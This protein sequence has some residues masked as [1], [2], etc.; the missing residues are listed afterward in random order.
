MP[1]RPTL[2]SRRRRRLSAV[3]DQLGIS[4][5]TRSYFFDSTTAAGRDSNRTG[6]ASSV[7]AEQAPCPAVATSPTGTHSY[8]AASR[9]TDP[10]FS[11]DQLGRTTALPAVGSV[12]GQGVTVGFYTNDL[13]REL[14]STLAGAAVAST[15]ILDTVPGRY[16]SIVNTGGPNAGTED[17]H[18]DDDGDNPSWNT[19][20]GAAAGSY[21]RSVTGPT[22]GLVATITNNTTSSSVAVALSNLHGDI[23]ATTTTSPATDGLLNTSDSTEYGATRDNTTSQRY[24]W[25]GAKQRAADTPGGLTLMGVRLYNPTLGRFLSVD[26]VVGGNANAYDYCT[27]DPINCTDLD[28]RF[29]WKKWIKR[30]TTVLSVAGMMG[31][32]V[33]AGVAAGLSVATGLWDVYHDRDNNGWWDVAGGGLYGAGK[34]FRYGNQAYKK[35]KMGHLPKGGESARA[36]KRARQNEAARHREF[37]RNVTNRVD[38]ADTLYGYYNLGSYGYHCRRNEC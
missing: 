16:R 3:Q 14:T 29:G 27:G 31:C 28:G 4:C 36:N 15:Y 6:Q 9:L 30:A 34:A 26:P 7:G 25:L 22:G 35:R 19:I 12:T 38:R 23:I 24:G 18:Y 8:D 11:Y 2:L 20:A 5:T 1:H 17:R 32:A 10:G 37:N 33:C 13:A 21:S